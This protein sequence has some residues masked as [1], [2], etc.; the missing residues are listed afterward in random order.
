MQNNRLSM[1][2][3]STK[4]K[5]VTAT[6]EEGVKRGM[7]PGGGLYMPQR[8][9]VLT[10]K[11][12]EEVKN[13]RSLA[14]TAQV[15]ARKLFGD[16]I[17]A[18]ALATLVE[19]ALNFDTPVVQVSERIYALELFHGPTLAFKDVG[20]RFMARLLQYYNQDNDA[21][22][23]VLV[24]TSGDTGSAV[25]NG[26]L[27]VPGIFV[28]VLYP[29]GQVS[30]LQ[31]KQ[32]TTLGQN[33]TALE[34][35]G[36]FDDCQALVKQAFADDELRSEMTLT[37]ANSINLARFLPQSFY[38][39]R[40]WSQ[41][42]TGQ[43]DTSFIN[44]GT[45]H[46]GRLRSGQPDAGGPEPGSPDTGS[47]VSGS[48]MSGSKVSN[49]KVSDIKVTDSKVTSR[50]HPHQLVVAVPSG[51]FG[52]LTAGLIA[53]E[54]GLPVHTF[55]AASNAN[56]VVP[57]YLDTSTYTPRAS[58]RTIANAMD[59]GAPSNFERILDL[60]GHSHDRIT[61]HLEGYR[62]SDDQIRKTMKQ[63]YETTGYILDPHGATGYEAA[64]EYIAAHP[65]SNVMFLETAHPAKF[66]ETVKEAIGTEADPPERLQAFAAGKK[67]TVEIAADYGTFR[68]YL[69]ERNS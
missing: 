56:D 54:M 16:D 53:R 39:F 55:L 11:E 34:V 8:I 42:V 45:A 28:H 4:N 43:F 7:A 51:N 36:S 58:V 9:P 30:A 27:G 2:Y 3:Y 1:I 18:D 46:P 19:D 59:V 64:V 5:K 68:K 25:A 21:P 10:R 13:S 63:V 50:Q 40:G 23:H 57:E 33:I 48:K 67:D 22:V 6:L 44:A 38:Y 14:A 20:A 26:F 49:S 37:S 65:G 66:P 17:P 15:I 31:E 61:Q 60:F 29:S 69:Q 35:E 12:L 32:F 62:Y 24:A 47:K 41:L 52:N